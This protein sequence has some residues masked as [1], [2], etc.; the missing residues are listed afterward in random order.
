MIVMEPFFNVHGSEIPKDAAAKAFH[1]FLVD[2]FAMCHQI[3]SCGLVGHEDCGRRV[4]RLGRLAAWGPTPALSAGVA[5]RALHLTGSGC[6]WVPRSRLLLLRS[7]G[8]VGRRGRR[9]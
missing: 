1:I 2:R 4:G 8:Q 6:L 7:C 5:F 9:S 3:Y